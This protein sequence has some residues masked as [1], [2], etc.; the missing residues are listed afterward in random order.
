MPR[1]RLQHFALKL[2]SS[3]KL[4]PSSKHSERHWRLTSKTIGEDWQLVSLERSSVS[5]NWRASKLE[6]N[7]DL[8]SLSLESS[9]G[10]P[11]SEYSFTLFPRRVKKV[12]SA[13]P[14]EASFASHAG[15]ELGECSTHPC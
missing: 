4:R 11:V 3:L 7:D 15:D 9:R 13:P 1:R 6:L 2:I 14:F 10:E 8:T 12:K 5:F